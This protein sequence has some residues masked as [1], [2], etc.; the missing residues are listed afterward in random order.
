MLHF[1]SYYKRARFLGF[2]KRMSRKVDVQLPTLGKMK[3]LI[4]GDQST[5]KTCLLNKYLNP[6]A[7]L[8]SPKPTIGIDYSSQR[9]DVDGAP[10]YIHYW[11]LS[12][13]DLY[14]EVRN[15]FYP[16][17]NGF[18]LV[19]D[20]SKRAT[21]DHLQAWIDEGTKYNAD[22]LTA[23]LVGTKTDASP[24][25]TND[26]ANNWA[27]KHSIKYYPTSA[28]S[29]EGIQD[30]FQALLSMIKKRQG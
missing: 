9:I 27:K 2:S 26:E 22:W 15:E 30:A 21:F 10:T 25:V 18:I 5:G 6:S 29:G 19:F 13:N 4:I 11:D 8:T 16:E 17:V 20:T 1:T 12:G 28:K 7:K 14:T 3:V 24:E 23:V